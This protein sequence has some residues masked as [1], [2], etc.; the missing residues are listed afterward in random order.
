MSG[1][2]LK[3]LKA[4]LERKASEPRAPDELGSLKEVIR[5]LYNDAISCEDAGDFTRGVQ[6]SLQALIAS[7]GEK[8]MSPE[9]YME[10]QQQVEETA[11]DEREFERLRQKL[12]R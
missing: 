4:R 9:E 3:A 5:M 10:Q 6:T 7:W 8:P 12:G 11:K 2:D 1:R